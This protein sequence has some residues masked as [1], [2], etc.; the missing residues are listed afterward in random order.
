MGLAAAASTTVG[1]VALIG[2]SL[3][4]GGIGGAVAAAA[5]SAVVNYLALPVFVLLM[6]MLTPGLIIS[7]VLPLIPYMLWIAGVTGWIILVCEAMI[8][9]P[10]WMLAHMTTG[11]DGLH[12]RAVDGWGL[13]FNVMFRPVLMVLGLLLSFFVFSAISWL[14]R[15]SFGIAAN[16]ALAGGNVVTNFLGL[17]VLLNIFVMTQVTA[18]FMSFR[19]IA[20][21]PH[22]LPRL[23]GFASASRVDMDSFAER[24]ANF[25]GSR[26]AGWIQQTL[27]RATGQIT[28]DAKERDAR[29]L[30][31]CGI[32]RPWT[33]RNVL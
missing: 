17:V 31:S 26:T 10:L 22:H 15:Q 24:A 3:I 32:H 9:V 25:T 19:M 6:A 13:L 20:L 29:Q 8:A 21:L 28:K 23:V 30:L 33:V 12:G 11:G 2:G 16:F 7:Y 14:I 5:A 27:G 4:S 18:A 1:S